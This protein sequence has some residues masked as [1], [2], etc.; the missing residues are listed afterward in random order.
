[1]ETLSTKC[2][3]KITTTELVELIIKFHK[4]YHNFEAI[5][6]QIP[7]HK[8]TCKDI[9]SSP[10]LLFFFSKKKCKNYSKMSKIL[11]YYFLL[12]L[13][14]YFFIVHKAKGIL[15]YLVP[16]F[17]FFF[18]AILYD[19]FLFLTRMPERTVFFFVVVMRVWVVGWFPTLDFLLLEI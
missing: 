7:N 5:P 9:N 11:I 3:T 10:C 2:T 19:T 14:F 1:M 15:L 18:F 13:N 8:N 16:F 4:N 12:Q 6:Q 17:S